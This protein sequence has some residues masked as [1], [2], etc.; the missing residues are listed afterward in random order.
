MAWADEIEDGQRDLINDGAGVLIKWSGKEIP[1]IQGS[2][3]DYDSIINGGLS[4]NIET[5]F[6]V[7]RSDI[8]RICGSKQFKQGDPVSLNKREMY[9]AKISDDEAD[10]SIRLTMESPEK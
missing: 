6:S 3:T 4:G 8:R 1:A 7:L 2:A 5:T 10:P 9:I